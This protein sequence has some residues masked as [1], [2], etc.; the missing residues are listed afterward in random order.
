[1]ENLGMTEGEINDIIKI[2][3]IVL[4]IGNIAFQKKDDDTAAVQN[5]K[6]F[7]FF[8]LIIIN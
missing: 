2:V 7:F 4:H 5:M 8:F 6:G 3:A 1:M